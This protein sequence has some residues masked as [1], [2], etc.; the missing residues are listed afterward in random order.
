VGCFSW[1]ALLLLLVACVDTGSG[2]QP[3]RIDP[4]Y[5]NANLLPQI[6]PELSPRLDVSI[7][8][9]VVTYLGNKVDHDTFAPGAA[10]RITHYWRVD[11]APG[12]GWRVFARLRGAPNSADF[13]N[14]PATDMELGHPT[15][16]WRAGEIIADVQDFV[17][18]PDWRSPAATL[19]VGLIRVGE[20]GTEDRMFA[21]G[22]HVVDR[23]VQA[24]E[25]RVDLSRAPPPPGTIYIPR[26]TGP[27][28]IDGVANEP[29]WQTAVQSGE[30]PTAEGS[31]EPIGK[32]TAKMTWD[33][34]NLYVFVSVTD[35]DIVS[36]YK[37][38]DDSLWKADDV[39]VFI[40]ADNN[41]KGYVELQVN[42]NNATFDSWFATTRA[43]PGDPS[44]DSGMRTMVKLRGTTEAND[45]DQGWD[46]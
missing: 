25:F 23:A 13:M 33:D 18:R 30:F 31:P 15:Q 26:A 10:V 35:T 28:A 27:I 22:A 16:D 19:E 24:R 32:A 1:R 20:H 17:L 42:P 40:D 37:K 45:T 46:A 44:W 4:A 5:I 38:H 8:P 7:G 3:K 12:P 29:S 21:E 34:D 14:L 6:P 11:K 39:E 2:P 41:R 36:E 9:G 43:Q